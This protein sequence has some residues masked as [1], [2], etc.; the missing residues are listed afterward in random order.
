MSIHFIGMQL[1]Y[2]CVSVCGREL[3]R[4]VNGETEFCFYIIFSLICDSQ[5]FI[6]IKYEARAEQQHPPVSRPKSV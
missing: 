1:M 6:I 5:I 4:R 2:V 3:R